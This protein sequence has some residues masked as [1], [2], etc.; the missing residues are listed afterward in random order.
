M[1]VRGKVIFHHTGTKVAE[2]EFLGRGLEVGGYRHYPI[3]DVWRC[4]T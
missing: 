1:D 3:V 2:V 4:F